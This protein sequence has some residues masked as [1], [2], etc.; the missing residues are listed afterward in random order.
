MRRTAF[1]WVSLAALTVAA[2]G[3][4]HRFDGEHACGEAIQVPEAKAL[5]FAAWVKI[6][7]PG[8][9]DRSYPRI[10][11]APA[12]YL[13]PSIPSDGSGLAGVTFGIVMPEKPSSWGFNGLLPTIGWVQVAITAGTTN[14]YER[15]FPELW[16]NGEEAE[17][18]MKGKPLPSVYKGGTACLGNTVKGGNRPFEGVIAD[19][20]YETRILSAAEIAALAKTAP[21][22][23]PPKKIARTLRDE[24]PVVDLTQDTFRQ[25]VIAM[26]TPDTYQGHPT[27][28]LTPDGK[29]LFCVW[30]INHGGGCGPA[31]RSDDGGYSW[32]RI[33]DQ[34]PAQYKF[35]RNCPTLQ[36]VPRPDGSG[37][38]F[39]AFSANCQ[40]GTG[41]GL[42]ILMSCDNGK[43]WWVTPP[44]P[45]LSAGMPPT[46]FLPLKDGTS[47]LFGQVRKNPQVKTDRPADDQAVW[48]SV[49]KDGGFTW[50]EPRIVA[51]AENKN[52]CEPFA[53][54]SPDG[55]EIGLLIRENRH[56]AR[57]MMCF[58]RDEGKTW[59][60]PEDTCW[61]L[62]GD[63][64]EG[65]PLPDGRWVVAFRDRALGSSTY[66]QY[67]AW[68]G[69]YDDLRHGRPGQYRIHLMK[70]WSGTKHGGWCGDT[71]YSGV[72][73]LPDGTIL[74]TTYIKLYPDDRLQS[75]ACTRFRIAET[76]RLAERLRR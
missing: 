67:V 37:V 7:G 33:D 47:A 22:G 27:T 23:Q 55:N 68:V 36:T 26:G 73:L 53:L 58:S 32:T 40:P 56:T 50:G 74:C 15:G 34:L 8:K 5:T 76:D 52:L 62:T 31:A 63:R 1:A 35:H 16:I 13:H 9:G 10:I 45:H 43:N 11:Q 17:V 69:S 6:E 70:S 42:G 54:R 29:T 12:F 30:T 57:S 75:V 38:N 3:D 49:T 65:V 14:E 64:H 2:A 71:G 41:G 60:Q 61:G 72:E 66:G 44:A 24:L 51:T 20:R 25:T 19:V 21:D 48:M 4:L 39:C 46:G 28:L 18:G 59:T